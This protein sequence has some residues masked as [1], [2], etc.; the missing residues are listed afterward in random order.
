MKMDKRILSTIVAFLCLAGGVA[1]QSVLHITGNVRSNDYNGLYIYLRHKDVVDREKDRVIDSARIEKGKYTLDVPLK[2]GV[3]AVGYLSLPPKDREFVYGLE[4]VYCI[5]EPGSITLDYTPDGL[6]ISGGKVNA[7]YERTILKSSREARRNGN[8]IV[9][10]RDSVEKRHQL[11]NEEMEYY[12]DLLRQQFEQ[13]KPAYVRFITDNIKN[14]AGAFFFLTYPENNYAPGAYAALRAQVNPVYL[15]RQK[16]L[17]EKEQA[18]QRAFRQAMESTNEGHP[19]RNFPS[20]TLDGKAVQLSDFVKKGK[21]TLI[22]FWAS[23]CIPCAQEIPALKKLYA[24]YHDKGFDIVSVSL[25]TN[26]NAWAGAVKRHQ[27]PWTQISDLK[28]WKGNATKLYGISAI[29]FVL[30]VDRNGI[31]VQK[32]IHG[33]RLAD[34]IKELV[35]KQ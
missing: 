1:A 30:V 34:K 20:Q 9:A 19:Y 11:S 17:R 4:D 16:E 22:D 32:N 8:R 2:D 23:W 31:I 13:T 14:D 21:V 35:G 26:K 28:G 24:Q 33:D 10:Q 3:P 29:P 5:L 6:Q 27:M 12:N 15:Q 25:D 7:E 18:E